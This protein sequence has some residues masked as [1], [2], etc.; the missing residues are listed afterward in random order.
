MKFALISCLFWCLL[1]CTSAQEKVP[2]P[3]FRGVDQFIDKAVDAEKVAGGCVLVLHRGKVVYQRGFGYADIATEKPFTIGTPAIV[4]SISK[5]MLGTAAFRLQEQGRLDLSAS[6][7]NQLPAFAASKLESGERIPRGPTCIE[8]FTHTGGLRGDSAPGGRPWFATWIR[9]KTLEQ[10]VDRFAAEVPFKAAPGSRY[11]YSGIGTDIAARVLEV[12][13]DKPRNYLFVETLAKPLG[14]TNTWYRDA[15]AIERLPPMPTRYRV[16]KARGL[17][18]YKGRPVAET[19]TYSSS[20][21]TVVSTAPDLS[22][23]LLM[24]RNKGQHEGRAFLKPETVAT[25]LS[26][27]PRGN[28]ARGGFFRRRTDQQGR[29]LV[30]GHTGSSGTNC[31]IDFEKDVIG[32][33]LTQT[34]G[35]DIRAFRIDLEKRISRCFGPVPK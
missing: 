4:A 13:T 33:M 8:L 2:A 9:G 35:R 19:D 16:D 25:M 26:A 6:I 7:T 22:R 28:N 14:M 34:A 27:G 11:A 10:A 20:G 23:W 1:A 12:A 3:D 18:V 29:A 31:W 32:I 5:P 30:I 21:G 24:I 15:T 17:V